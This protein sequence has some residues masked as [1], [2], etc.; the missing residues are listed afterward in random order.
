[1]PFH[2]CINTSEL[3]SEDANDHDGSV[4]LNARLVY[5]GSQNELPPCPFP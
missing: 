2:L 3:L 4:A 1:M 5:S